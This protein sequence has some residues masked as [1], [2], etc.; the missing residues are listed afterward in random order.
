MV[1]NSESGFTLLEVAISL[2]L[3]ATAL[4]AVFRL[5][6]QNL[7]LQ[8][9]AQFLTVA[10]DIAQDRFSR[11]ESG[12]KFLEGTDTGDCGEDFP[13]FSYQSKIERVLENERLYKIKVS[14][15]QEHNGLLKD[16]SIETFLY[17]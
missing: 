11:I 17:R 15:F 3:I 6:A 16:F 2:C 12:E 1:I 14:I 13:H 8:Y 7:D 10:K 4:L 5:Q 9:E